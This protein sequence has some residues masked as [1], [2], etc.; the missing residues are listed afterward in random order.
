MLHLV[1]LNSLFS[2]SSVAIINLT[3]TAGLSQTF[4]HIPHFQRHA[5]QHP[6]SMLRRKCLL[7]WIRGLEET[8]TGQGQKCGFV[9]MYLSSAL[10]LKS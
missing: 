8:R 7:D 10:E 2:V 3:L 5:K 6:G 4:N 9:K 1:H